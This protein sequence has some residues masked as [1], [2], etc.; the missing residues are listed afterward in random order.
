[1]KVSDNKAVFYI[2]HP[3]LEALKTIRAQSLFVIRCLSWHQPMALEWIRSSDLPTESG[4][5]PTKLWNSN[6]TNRSW[7]SQRTQLYLEDYLSSGKADVSTHYWDTQ[8]EC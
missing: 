4:T 6:W 5:L 3:P 8:S 2:M 7:A 1:M